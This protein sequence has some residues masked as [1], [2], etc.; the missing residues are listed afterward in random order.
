MDTGN[1]VM[2]LDELYK[3][4]NAHLIT[5]SIPSIYL[6]NAIKKPEFQKPPFHLLYQLKFTEQSPIH[7]PEGNVWNHTLLVVDEAAKRKNLCRDPAVFMWASL[8]HDIGKPSTTENKNGKITSYNHDKIGANLAH[9]FLSGFTK[10]QFFIESVCSF[11]E[12]HMHI[13]YVVK[14][15][16][17]ANIPEMLK[18]TDIN[19]I[20]LLGLCD[21][22]GRK[23]ASPK[24]EE[25]TIRHFVKIC[26]TFERRQ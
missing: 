23:G 14:K 13:L 16:P 21:R 22:L 18:K 25:N 20:A 17:Y 19:E 15:L 12:F 2:S 7:H 9:D 3:D 8:L 1:I 4:V 11:I 24:E 6:S 26:K 5:D 10:D